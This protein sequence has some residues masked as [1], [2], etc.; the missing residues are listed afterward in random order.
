MPALV[1]GDLMP[2]CYGMDA[3]RT[4]YS[5][6]EQAGRATVI[7]LAW[8][9]SPDRL[10]PLVRAFMLSSASFSARNADMLLL[11]DDD[12]LRTY[13]TVEGP[14]R[15]DCG[16]RFLAQCGVAPGQPVV[17]V[18]DRGLRIARVILIQPPRAL[19]L[20]TF[21]SG[22]MARGAGGP[23]GRET[24]PDTSQQPKQNCQI[25]RRLV[26]SPAEGAVHDCLRALDALPSEQ[27]RTITLPAPL[28]MLPNVL[29]RDFCR[30]LI[31]TFEASP[32]VDGSVAT[33]G[34]DGTPQARV[35]PAKKRRR[36]MPVLPE[37]PLHTQLREL[38]LRRCAPPIAAAFQARVGHTDRI[39]IARYDDSGGYFRRHRDNVAQN[40]AFREFAISVNLNA[41]DYEGG[42]L[43]FPEFNDHTYRPSTGAAIIFSAS[44]LHEAMPVTHG[45]RYVLLTFF[46]GDAAEA[47]RI[48]YLEQDHP[49][50]RVR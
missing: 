14:R 28:L 47:R 22:D 38:L 46:H 34:C 26:L 45:R 23:A 50:L 9:V 30:T 6:E 3:K 32:A 1:P 31:E 44:L 15:V 36:D 24:R 12:L 27:P 5:F 16:L 18:I 35:D 13:R 39:L 10:E 2:F 33:I 20:P 40:V 48:A 17:V 25:E 42:N 21:S 43:R 29:S 4:F 19:T 11:G 8:Q 41:E 37:N 49:N 7:I